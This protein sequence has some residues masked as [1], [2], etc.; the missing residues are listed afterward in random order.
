M[1][2]AKEIKAARAKVYREANKERI[3]AKKAADAKTEHG[4]ALNKVRHERYK[5]KHPEHVRKLQQKARAK[6]APLDK[7]DARQ[8]RIELRDSYVAQIL[9]LPTAL[10]PPEIIEVERIRL[11][12]KRE[13]QELNKHRTEKKC[14]ACNNYKPIISFSKSRG[15]KDGYSYEC[16]ICNR[17]RKRRENQKKGLEYKPR[18]FDEFGRHVRHTP[19]E[20]R[21][22][23]NAR[24][25][26]RYALNKQRKQ[27]E[28]HQ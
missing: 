15:T 10:V 17:E 19:E 4:R 8:K 7:A 5:A 22:N 18:K 9:C 26:E 23:R 28:T 1:A 25:R 2:T 12:I 24:E 27:N 14:C 3:A 16:S 11:K 21:A 13:I 6:R 20:L